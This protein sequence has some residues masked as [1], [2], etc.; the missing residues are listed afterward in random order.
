MA[1]SQGLGWKAASFSRGLFLLSLDSA[2]HLFPILSI[3]FEKICSVMQFIAA[4]TVSFSPLSVDTF[5]ERC[6]NFKLSE[7]FVNTVTFLVSLKYFS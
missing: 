3:T 1:Q 6:Y 4:E 2:Y 7:F 5:V